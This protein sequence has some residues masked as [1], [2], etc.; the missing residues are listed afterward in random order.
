[1][2]SQWGSQKLLQGLVSH[3]LTAYL[4]V[5]NLFL[6]QWIMAI[7]SKGCKPHN[8]EPHKSL[9]L[10][11]T[12]ILGHHF[13]FCWMWIFPWIRLSWHSCSMW[14]NLEWLNWFWQFLFEGLSSFNLKRFNYSYVWSYSLKERLPFAWDLSLENP[15]DSILCFRLLL[16][17]SVSHFFFLYQSP[18]LLLCTIF[19]S[20]SSNRWGSLYQPIY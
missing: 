15:M 5:F 20:V 4:S 16:L 8:L 19:D 11:F 3:E 7:L 17:H 18:S 2:S 14:D 6:T 13:Q 12:N 10:S 9:N 1:M